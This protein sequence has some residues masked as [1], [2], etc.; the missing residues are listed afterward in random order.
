MNTRVF[1]IVLS[2]ITAGFFAMAVAA[3]TGTED[4]S[5]ARGGGLRVCPE[6]WHPVTPPLNPVLLCLPDSLAID[7]GREEAP[8]EGDCPEGWDRVTPPLNPVLGCLPSTVVQVSVPDHAAR[9]HDGTCPQGFRPATP[10][11]NPVLGCLPD[12][13]HLPPIGPAAGP[14]PPGSCP[15]GWYPVT[16]PLN[17]MLL[18][19]PGTLAPPSSPGGGR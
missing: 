2:L 12:S 3:G 6:G 15:D 4:V 13:F 5:A 17:P 8:P 1:K 19:L 7:S 14:I 11:L 18:C 16:P 9:G 10:P